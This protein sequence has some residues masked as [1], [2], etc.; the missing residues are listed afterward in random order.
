MKTIVAA[1]VLV[2]SSLALHAPAVAAQSRIQVA[3]S[4]KLASLIDS[5][6]AWILDNELFARL[7][8]GLNIK[9]LPGISPIDIEQEALFA[10]RMRADLALSL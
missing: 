1:F 8:A 6:S 5:Y 9:R 7:S 3:T 4:P 10:K 2:S